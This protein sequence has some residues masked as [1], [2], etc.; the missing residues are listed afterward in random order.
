MIVL[1]V[2][3]KMYKFFAGRFF[4]KHNY[5]L[6]ITLEDGT[7]YSDALSQSWFDATEMVSLSFTHNAMQVSD[8]GIITLLDNWYEPINF[9]LKSKC[10]SSEISD[11]ITREVSIKP[12][13]T[14]ISWDVDIN[15]IDDQN[16][17][18]QFGSLLENDSFLLNIKINAKRGALVT[19]SLKLW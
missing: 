6:Q 3:E 15:R 19:W 11:I 9:D 2:A 7:K 1:N 13:L 8:A 5:C 16:I 10:D 17:G 14:P 18:L 4:Y 12:N